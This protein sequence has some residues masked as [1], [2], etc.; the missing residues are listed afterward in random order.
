V[1]PAERNPDTIARFAT[2]AG[3]FCATVDQHAAGS[4]SEFLRAMHARLPT[5]YAA[6]L[7]LPA[8]EADEGEDDD[9]GADEPE[10]EIA[11][12]GEVQAGG[13]VSD[14]PGYEE[15]RALYR[16]LARSIGEREHYAEVFDPY[17]EPQEAPVTG[18]LADDLADIYRDLQA[19]LTAWQRGE[20]RAALWAW[21]FQFTVHWG[22]HATSALRALHALAS[23]HDLGFPEV[24]R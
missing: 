2:L 11:E 13:P 15:W 22:E 16:A 20:I 17:A 7:A 9:R 12:T 14:R 21:R 6:A 8:V 4:P 18:S 24:P 23:A 10:E 19:G 3:D 1:T 5:L